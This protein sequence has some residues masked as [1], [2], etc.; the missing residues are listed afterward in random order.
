MTWIICCYVISVWDC[1]CHHLVA[2]GSC[3]SAQ[4]L[5]SMYPL[6][7]RKEIILSYATLSSCGNYL[8]DDTKIDGRRYW[9]N[10]ASTNHSASEPHAKI[11]RP[12]TLNKPHGLHSH[13][14]TL[15]RLFCN[16]IRSCSPKPGFPKI[17]S[18]ATEICGSSPELSS[19]G[20]EGACG[21]KVMA[22]VRVNVSVIGFTIVSTGG[23]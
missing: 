8:G 13:L 7:N 21:R 17:P 10:V 4:V 5:L 3:A 2:G 15:F 16:I 14:G 12:L 20:P 23:T 11:K 6:S 1:R 18:F 22:G 19:R 9:P